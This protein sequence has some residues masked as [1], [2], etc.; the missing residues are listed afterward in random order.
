MQPCI[1]V[2]ESKRLCPPLE[3]CSDRIHRRSFPLSLPKQEANPTGC[4]QFQG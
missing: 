2:K 1:G 4:C 3:Q